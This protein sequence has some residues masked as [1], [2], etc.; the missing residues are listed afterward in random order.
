MKG[1]MF[2]DLQLAHFDCSPDSLIPLHITIVLF[3]SYYDI[4]NISPYC[5]DSFRNKYKKYKTFSNSPLQYKI[6]L[7]T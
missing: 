4:L 5:V 6:F 2:E 3:E 1:N 7:K